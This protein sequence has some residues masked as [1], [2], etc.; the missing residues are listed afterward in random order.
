MKAVSRSS[1]I[2]P[3][4]GHRSVKRPSFLKRPVVTI[5]RDLILSR[6]LLSVIFSSFVSRFLKVRQDSKTLLAGTP[7]KQHFNLTELHHYYGGKVIVLWDHLPAHHAA[8]TYFE[9]THPNWF[10]FEY[11]PP[12]SPEL[13]PVES[14]WHRM[15]NVYLPNFVP[16]ANEELTAAVQ[17]AASQINDDQILHATFKHAGSAP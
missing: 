7:A 11:F 10:E 4:P 3:A 13:N 12:Y 8:A 16:T 15:K 17:T 9:N 2:A 5:T 6:E 14:C 1:R